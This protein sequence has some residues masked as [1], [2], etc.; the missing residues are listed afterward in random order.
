MAKKRDLGSFTCS[1]KKVFSWHDSNQRPRVYD[2]NKNLNIKTRNMI[3]HSE[4]LDSESIRKDPKW[5]LKKHFVLHSI[6]HWLLS[7][8]LGHKC[9]R[10]YFVINLML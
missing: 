3:Y 10:K 9:K 4:H 8:F 5:E 7:N 2:E 1:L 6:L